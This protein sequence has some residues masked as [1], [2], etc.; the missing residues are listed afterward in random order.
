VVLLALVVLVLIA[1]S[2]IYVDLIYGSS[3]GMHEFGSGVPPMAALVS[4]LLLTALNQAAARG[5]LRALNR[6]ELLAIYAIVSVSAPLVSHGCL[7]WMLSHNIGLHYF[8]RVAPEWRAVFLDA[9]PT[10]FAP[11]NGAELELFFLGSGPVPWDQWLLPAAAWA[12]FLL[13]LFL[14]S[15]ALMVLFGE[16]WIARERLTFPIAQ[17]PLETIQEGRFREGE[18]GRLPGRS[19][20]WIGF[21]IPV[22]MACINSLAA[23]FPAIP[24]LSSPD[25]EGIML[26]QAPPTGAL[27]G[28][29]NL[30]ISPDP[31][32]IALAFLLPKDLSFSCWFF[33]W[34]RVGLVVMAVVL[35]DRELV[36]GRGM[37]DI[38][39]MG[40]GAMLAIIGLAC[41]TGRK[42]LGRAV[43]LALGR[44]F[45]GVEI[46][47]TRR[48]RWA[49]AVALVSFLYLGGFLWVAGAQPLVAG[50]GAGLLLLFYVAWARIRAETGLA[51]LVPPMNPRDMMMTSFGGTYFRPRDVIA[52]FGIRWAYF[53]SGGP[54]PEVITGN[55]IEALKIGDAA[56]VKQRPLVRAIIIGFCLILVLGVYL[57]LTTIHKYGLENLHIMVV[58]WFRGHL[59]WSGDI[60]YGEIANPSPRR[61]PGLIA[62]GIGAIVAI[63]LGMMRLMFWW[64]PLHPVGFFVATC[65]GMHFLW[66]PFFV[67]WLAK[68][69]TLRY[70]GLQLYRRLVPVAIGMIMGDM[71]GRALWLTSSVIQASML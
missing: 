20:F 16:Q 49:L 13:A 50:V 1:Y 10:W 14:S 57:V 52:L 19:V 46:E 47:E 23:R 21:T 44:T 18:F 17:V 58:G 24:A 60:L 59:H 30:L 3:T 53:P 39:H 40:A 48:Y 6:R 25:G 22:V 41:W 64:W 70:G 71:V 11:S 69:L 54:L 55:S 66:F 7:T 31:W 56:G 34:V 42:H 4:L 35:G 37:L 67:G 45:P 15:F 36:E 33:R 32:L 43:Q 2:A 28:V 62:M 29:G 65:W 63:T 61:V 9:M 38:Y 12:S 26:W 27:S 8:G 5:G 68:T 51:F